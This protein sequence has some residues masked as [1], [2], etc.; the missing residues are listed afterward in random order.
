MYSL[1]IKTT[2]VINH[3]MTA[4]P[5]T[6]SGLLRFPPGHPILTD[7]I[8]YLVRE[9]KVTKRKFSGVVRRS[10]Y[11]IAHHAHHGIKVYCFVGITPNHLHRDIPPLQIFGNQSAPL[12]I[13]GNQSTSFHI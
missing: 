10:S 2:S 6:M 8:I 7:N 5:T 9:R 12:Q 4:I 3:N 13:F 1:H 11:T